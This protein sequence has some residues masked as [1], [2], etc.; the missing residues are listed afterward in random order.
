MESFYH[1]PPSSTTC[2][3][4]SPHPSLGKVDLQAVTSEWLSLTMDTTP[5]PS[6]TATPAPSLTATPIPPTPPP[7][8]TDLTPFLKSWEPESP[9]P[10]PSQRGFTPLPQTFSR[11]HPFKEETLSLG[12]TP[13]TLPFSQPPPPPSHPPPH[14]HFSF[15]SPL[16]DS[17]LRYNSGRGLNITETAQT[18]H[19]ARPEVLS[20]TVPES[21][22]HVPQQH[23]STVQATK[24]SK[25]PDIELHVKDPYDELLSMILDGSSSTDNDA[26]L[27][28]AYSP[29]A[30][31]TDKYK[32]RFKLKAEESHQ[33][34]M[35]PPAIQPA[36][37]LAGSI[38]L[39]VQFHKP[40]AMEPLSIMWGGQSK[41]LSEQ[42]VEVQ[43]PLSVK[44][45]EYTELFIEEDDEAREDKEE[46]VFN[47][48]LGPQAEVCP[49][50]L[51]RLP[52]PG[53]PSTSRPPP[54]TSLSPPAS[55]SAISVSLSQQHDTIAPSPSV[56]P[57]PPS[58]PHLTTSP[59]P[60]VSPSPLV[61]P[62]PLS[63]SHPSPNLPS[64]QHSASHPS[65]LS[66]PL[67]SSL[68]S[69]S[70]IPLPAL[71]PQL[72][73]SPPL[74]TPRSSPTV[75]HPGRRSP[76]VKDPVVGGKP[77][78]SPI[79]S[80]RS[81]LSAIRGRR[82]L[83]QDALHG[84]GDPY[85][86]LYNYQPRNEDELELKEGDIVDVME[87]CDDG[88]FVGTS[89]RSKLFGTFPGNYVKQL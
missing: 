88:W 44:G 69:G 6:L 84:G 10:A 43:R 12:H 48:R 59:P 32:G 82:R 74:G 5:A 52:H 49:S 68:R 38:Q 23:K 65:P 36:S 79:L 37:E 46:D 26:V 21:Q 15:T 16:P 67:P 4:P 76:K 22:T 33:P 66:R 64:S 11:I 77:P 57:C 31:L 80:R 19:V 62:P 8:P 34:A 9:S 41:P 55:S 78:R 83:V 1:L 40:V 3:L 75:P 18:S 13:V 71:S 85:Q 24:S 81:Y 70:P 50:A 17:L 47:E 53:L 25:T 42:P 29:P 20:C 63:S 7:L 30:M 72:P 89:R 39:E 87:K 58:L 60:P 51:T 28:E 73:S 27:S 54:Q 2:D 14:S 45:K 86:A 35:K 61:S 56:S